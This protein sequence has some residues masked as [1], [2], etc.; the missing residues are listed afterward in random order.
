MNPRKS[1]L[2]YSA[3]TKTH[4]PQVPVATVVISVL[5]FLGVL[6]KLSYILFIDDRKNGEVFELFGYKYLSHFLWAFGNEVFAFSVGTL[7]FTSTA[8][9]RPESKMKMPYRFCAGLCYAMAT[10]FSVWIFYDGNKFTQA[11]EVFFAIM[12]SVV[13]A[14]V[15]SIV[16]LFMTRELRSIKDLR[17]SVLEFFVEI[18]EVHYMRMLL[19]VLGNST[20]YEAQ[21]IDI[22]QDVEEFDKRLMEKGI[23]IAD[24]HAEKNFKKA[25]KTGQP[26]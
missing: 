19:R 15:F 12:F 18:K 24:H 16:L 21:E 17:V 5:A 1:K 4:R 23:E 3:Q 22:K 14:V 10:Y 26:T 2:S 20:Y 7:L 25:K 6:A 8:F 9:F 13:A 11:V